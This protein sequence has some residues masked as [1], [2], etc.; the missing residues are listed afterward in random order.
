M[1]TNLPSAC[2]LYIVFELL[3]KKNCFQDLNWLSCCR[4]F[5]PDSINQSRKFI[6]NLPVEFL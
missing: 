4:D 3:L 2:K 5:R 1:L 6:F